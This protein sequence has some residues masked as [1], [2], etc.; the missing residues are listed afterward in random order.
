MLNSDFVSEIAAAKGTDSLSEKYSEIRAF[1]ERICANLEKEDFVL[2]S[3]TD[4]SPVRWHLAHTT[5]FFE[6]F[7]LREFDPD[8]NPFDPHFA[9]LF[10]SY[11]VQAGERFSRPDRGLLSRPVVDEIYTYRQYV[12][13]HIDSLLNMTSEL[14]RAQ[15]DEIHPL[16]HIKYNAISSCI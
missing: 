2:Q 7:V 10:N 5:W 14:S 4:A 11:Y 15:T 6:T 8:Y 3:M 16:K 1:T 12:N 9:F 13:K